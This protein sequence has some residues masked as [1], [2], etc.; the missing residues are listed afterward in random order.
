MVGQP[1]GRGPGSEGRPACGERGPPRPIVWVK[2]SGAR[3]L[4]TGAVPASRNHPQ[5]RQRSAVPTAWSRA[6]DGGWDRR[7][8]R[9]VRKSGSEPP[10]PPS[11]GEGRDGSGPLATGV[12]PAA[13]PHRQHGGW[14]VTNGRRRPAVGLNGFPNVE[15]TPGAGT[16]GLPAPRKREAGWPLGRRRDAGPARQPAT[17]PVACGATAKPFRERQA[18]LRP[19]RSSPASAGG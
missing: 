7:C 11:R 13:S 8:A 4:V 17:R 6:T 9:A 1:D 5:R 3:P 10:T 14:S 2:I 12:V 15:G 18:D 16:R 19:G